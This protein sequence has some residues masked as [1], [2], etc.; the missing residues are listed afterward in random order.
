MLIPI[1]DVEIWC[2]E[3]ELKYAFWAC[4]TGIDAD[5]YVPHYLHPSRFKW[6]TFNRDSFQIWPGVTLHH[7]PGHTEGSI[8][9][10]V[11][12][13]E[14]GHV[15]MTG[16]LFHVRE[17]WE[18]GRPQG[19]LCRDWAAWHRSLGFVRHLVQLRKGRILLGH[20][21]AYFERF[22]VSPGFLA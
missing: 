6:K 12:L 4:A 18:D 17:N 8:T 22:P 19:F 14:S 5:L 1:P 15:I 3:S 13:L 9:M 16:D 11:A 7:T 20:E 2:H 10:E 21:M